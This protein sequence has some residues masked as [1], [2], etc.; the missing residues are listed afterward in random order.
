MNPARYGEVGGL[1]THR[2]DPAARHRHGPVHRPRPAVGG[3]HRP[4]VE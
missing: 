1:G 2:E 3:E 4:V